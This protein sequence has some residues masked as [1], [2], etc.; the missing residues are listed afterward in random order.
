ML[1]KLNCPQD[2]V[3]DV[4][5]CYL[6]K[7]KRTGKNSKLIKKDEK[8]LIKKEYDYKRRYIRN[9]KD[10][11][12]TFP[13]KKLI[14][15]FDYLSTI[16]E[17]DAVKE[18]FQKV[19]FDNNQHCCAICGHELVE[20][21][22]DHVL[23]KNTFPEYWITPLNLVPICNDCNFAKNIEDK[24][25][26]HCVY[27]SYLEDMDTLREDFK[28]GY[29]IIFSTNDTFKIRQNIPDDLEQRV[30]KSYR[31]DIRIKYRT[32]IVINRIINQMEFIIKNSNNE[33]YISSKMIENLLNRIYY[34]NKDIDSIII[35]ALIK[36]KSAFE[37]YIYSKLKVKVSNI[38][39]SC[40]D[41]KTELQKLKD[42]YK[43]DSADN[44]FKRLQ[45]FIE[46]IE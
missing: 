28:K 26:I 35:N 29:D 4:I 31:L 11:K 45:A 44:H 43:I 2:G 10:Y 9:K 34:D 1:D 32:P 46:S 23:P 41:A 19:I 40:I 17:D 8:Y 14:K 37:L 20:S 7:K 5:S 13:N 6:S 18:K 16:Y 42:E 36:N 21:V 15:K 30:I 12:I 24:R 33:M 25:G 39:I 22:I 27:N 3:K 38:K